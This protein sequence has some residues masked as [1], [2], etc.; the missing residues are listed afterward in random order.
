MRPVV[1]IS[2]PGLTPRL[3]GSAMPHL[4]RLAA[5]AGMAPLRAILPA[6]TCSAQ[7]TMLTGLSPA[8]HGI[9]ANGWHF[10]ELGETLLWRQ[11]NK[12]VSGEKIW[13]SA[14]RRDPAFTCAN[15]FWW[16][17]M[18]TG[19]DISATPRPIYL[20]DGRKLPDC[21]TKPAVLH[22]VLTSRFGVFPLFRF[23]GPAT[24]IEAS[25]WIANAALYVRQHHQPTLTLVYLPHLDYDLQRLGPNDPAIA[26]ALTEVDA[27]CGELIDDARRDDAAVIVVSEYG[28]T[29]VSR[30]IHINRALRRAGLLQVR[31]ER[32]REQ[33]DPS[34]SI[35]F[36]MSDHQIAHVYVQDPSRVAE[37]AALLRA[38][39]GVE[40]VLDKDGKHTEGLDHERSGELVAVAEADAWFTWYHWLDDDKAPD[41]ARTVDIHRKP[42]YDPVELFLDPTFRFPRLAVATRLFRRALGFRTPLDVIP[43]D[44]SLVKGSHGRPTDD[45]SD[46]P[47]VIGTHQE[48]QTDGAVPMA[49]IKDIVLHQL[50]EGAPA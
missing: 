11:S 17:A 2:V 23:W 28:I 32:G 45:L 40:R 1:L 22:D 27:L 46:G 12:L 6:V 31:G 24:S 18:H 39:P 21:Y 25:R 33:L 50:F 16:Y 48:L 5:K 13:E 8:G 41:F 26:P 7:S 42:G 20:A 38:M 19:A 44:A 15:L 30:S 14:K 9:V 3:L 35:A 34:A 47:L 10:R 36:A 49:A 37:V 29:P 4:S 43:L